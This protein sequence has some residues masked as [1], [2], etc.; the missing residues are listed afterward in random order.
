MINRLF[1][2]KHPAIDSYDVPNSK[3]VPK[4]FYLLAALFLMFGFF[5]LSG[6][7]ILFYIVGIVVPLY[8]GYYGVRYAI[9]ML[10]QLIT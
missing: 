1:K 9:R 5:I 8:A 6:S 3:K 7:P 2:A 4:W 10:K